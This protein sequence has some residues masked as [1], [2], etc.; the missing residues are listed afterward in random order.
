MEREIKELKH[1]KHE[2]VEIAMVVEK[3]NEVVRLLMDHEMRIGH[4][5]KRV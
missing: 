4:A 3:L 5:T 2:N 1:Y